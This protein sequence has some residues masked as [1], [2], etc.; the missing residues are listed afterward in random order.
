MRSR[1][2]AKYNPRLGQLIC[3]KISTGTS[4]LAKLC[5]EEDMPHYT[6]VLRWLCDPDKKEFQQAYLL[7]RESQAD[8]LNDEIIEIADNAVAEKESPAV[9]SRVKLRIDARKWKAGKLA[10]KKN[11]EKG[12]GAVKTGEEEKG[13]IVNWGGKLIAL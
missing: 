9:V 12:S 10:P 8:L 2:P 13:T 11:S 3:D 5:S 7:A 4:G 1:R 6:T